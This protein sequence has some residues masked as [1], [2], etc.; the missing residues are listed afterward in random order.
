M[1]PAVRFVPAARDELREAAAWYEERRSGLGDQFVD[2][3]EVAL[4]LIVDWT[5]A[6]TPVEIGAHD[7]RRLSVIGFPYHLPY[8]VVG[9][10]IEIVAVAH[11]RRRPAYWA[12]RT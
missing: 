9:D 10:W 7:V 2:A 6:G 8:R 12:G 11:D 4:E 1:S 3:V 5:A